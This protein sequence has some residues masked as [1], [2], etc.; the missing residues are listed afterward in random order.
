MKILF[1]IIKWFFIVIF[2]S[3]ILLFIL[4][5][6][7]FTI[8]KVNGENKFIKEGKYPLIIPHGGAKKLA[9]ENTV[10]SYEML[11]DEY[12]ADVLEIDL[13]LTKDG[14]LIT[15]HDLDLEMSEASPLNDAFIR[16]YTYNEILDAYYE[17]DYY[18]ARGFVDPNGLYPFESLDKDSD[19]MSKMV[20]AVLED[21]FQDVGDAVLYILEIKDSPTSIGY[22]EGSN[23]FEEAASELIRLVNEYELGKNVVLGSFSDDV[24]SFFRKEA[25]N[26]MIGA[27][28]GEVTIFAVL[29]AFHIDF[30]WGVKSEVL[31]LP[32]PE[33]MKIPS[34]LTSI[35]NILPG[36]IKDKIAIKDENGEYRANLM[37][38]QIIKDAH[39]KNL[40]VLYWT[41]NDEETM[42]LLI[43]NGA[44]GIITDRPDLLKDVIE[45]LEAGQ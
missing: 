23:R 44:D 39:R 5:I 14:I 8:S 16:D 11:I 22:Q 12:N 31:I 26:I 21:I 29:S 13:A 15:H 6:V 40:A 30:F 9:P 32:I 1:K 18:L 19:V 37:H 7:P 4:D 42:E 28:T 2:I 24:T 10:Y 41:V 3:F 27:A 17:D 33:S 20:P 45:R 43:K 35:L 38:K 25:P 36:F 34:S